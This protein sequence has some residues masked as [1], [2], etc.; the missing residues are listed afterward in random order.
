MRFL[1]LTLYGICCMATASAAESTPILNRSDIQWSRLIYE[2]SALFMTVQ[3]EVTLNAVEKQVA[4]SQLVLKNET[5]VHMP[6]GDTVFQMGTYS[7]SF[8]KKTSYN[9]WIDKQGQIL[10]RKKLVRGK[11]NEIK[12]YRFA[13]CGYY[14]LREKFSD[15]KFDENYSQWKDDDRRFAEFAPE[16]CDGRVIYDV[17]SLLYIITASNILKPGDKQEVLAFSR[18]RLFNVSL[19]AKKMKEIYADF[20]I[21]APSGK[22]SIEKKLKVLQVQIEPIG[23]DEKLND[24]FRFLGLKGKVTVYVD[25]SRKLIL[26]LSGHV[27]VLGSIDINLKNANLL[28]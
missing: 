28:K 23:G 1:F 14:T 11:K 6:Q 12:Y 19:E 22:K 7:D 18:D 3:T 8:G 15:K 2:A 26:R 21:S 4:I 25:L 20:S 10:Q 9:L 17:N 16:L 5:Y 24:D 13:P 27:D